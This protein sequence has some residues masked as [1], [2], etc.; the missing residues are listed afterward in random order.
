MIY[1]RNLLAKQQLENAHFYLRR[2]AYVAAIRRAT[3]VIQAFP[4]TPDQPRALEIMAR[5]Y[6]A[7][8]L[9]DLE[10]TTL[11]VLKH[12]YPDYEVLNKSGTLKP[13]P[14]LPLE[15]RSLTNIVTFG[16]MD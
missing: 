6:K 9:N 10:A 2:G 5:G 3:R 7:L 4:E 16:L 12:N 11:A 13:D 15:E 8:D 1:L 14:T